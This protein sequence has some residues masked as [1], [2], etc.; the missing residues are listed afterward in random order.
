MTMWDGL[1]PSWLLDWV[2]PIWCLIK[3]LGLSLMSCLAGDTCEVDWTAQ[4][5]SPTFSFFSLGFLLHRSLRS[6]L[7]CHALTPPARAAFCLSRLQAAPSLLPPG[8]PAAAAACSP[9]PCCSS[10]PGLFTRWKSLGK[11]SVSF[12]VVI[13]Q[14]LS[15][16]RLTRLKRF[17]STFTDKLYN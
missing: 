2:Q 15:N 12:F 14:N 16:H 17:V 7:A 4:G 9:R 6:A 13:W 5:V 8:A 11:V 1:A 3:R 10:R